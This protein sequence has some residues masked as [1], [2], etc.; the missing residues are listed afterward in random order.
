MKSKH[1]GLKRLLK[2]TQNSWQG[3]KAAWKLEEA[4]RQECVMALILIPIALF[5]NITPLE[6]L[7]LIVSVIFVLIVELF[8]SA[9]EAIV[10]RFGAEFHELS[11][12]AK[13]MASAC[14]TLSLV[15]MVIVWVVIVL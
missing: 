13:D 15:L 4:F 10:D 8:N 1:K 11:G 14:V 5:L 2:A 3:F 12:R 9:L 7:L 6:K